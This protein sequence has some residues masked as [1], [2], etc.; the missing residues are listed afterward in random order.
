MLGL[1]IFI[2]TACALYPYREELN[3]TPLPENHLLTS[4]EFHSESQ[5]FQ[6][7]ETTRHYTVFPRSIGSLLDSTNTKEVHLRFANGWWDPEVYGRLPDNG[8]HSGGTGIE[9][10]AGIDADTQEMAFKEWKKLANGLSGIF[11]ASL[12]FID[13]DST[14]IP[15]HL[16][17]SG[18]YTFRS[19]LARE[20]VC[21]ENLTPFVKMLP[22]S[23]KTGI[24]SLL[25]GHT[26]F[27]AQWTGMAIDAVKECSDGHCQYKL[28]QYVDTV[29]KVP[30]ALARVK[31]Q[32][33]RPIAGD[34]L[35]C[36]PSKRHD[37]FH[38]FPLEDPK[39]SRF[40]LKQV[41]GRVVEGKNMVSSS[42]KVCVGSQDSVWEAFAKLNHHEEP[43]SQVLLN[44]DND[45]CFELENHHRVNLELVSN[46]SSQTVHSKAP[47][48]VSRSATGRS[49]DFGK[50]QSRLHN[51]SPEPVSVVYV[52]SLPWFL[53]L[54]VNTMHIT[55]RDSRTKKV[56]QTI[57]IS[58]NKALEKL[59][60]KLYYQTAI[61]RKRP[62]HIELELEIPAYTIV[63]IGYEFEKSLLLY[64]EY[65]PD[66]N[67]GFDIEPAAVYVYENGAVKYQARTTS[68]VVSLPTPDFS[69]P[70]N[71]III[72]CTLMSLVFGAIFNMLAKRT[73]T[74]EE[75]DK[76]VG[77][78]GLQAKLKMFWRGEKQK[79]E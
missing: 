64:A 8:E 29:V 52:E 4:F 7:N 17:S 59:K 12:N 38:C 67:H 42:T 15:H 70:Y 61:D 63:T 19:A 69:M 37:A 48:L 31:N 49:Q 43:H 20:P 75:A 50:M 78:Y 60:G 1:P 3:V 76:L 74:E 13:S 23:G 21:T 66:A 30:K 28:D 71:V 39:E 36:D 24:A 35:R 44:G 45:Y 5:S 32:I 9:L 10:L 47:I 53:R 6:P 16:S 22:S 25:D 33:P 65:P 72:T 41:F 46:D 62:T 77:E 54:F 11:C 2:A 27:D 34:Q 57:S 56:H 55:L 68:L 73:V 40:D 18:R 58:D 79:K 26:V 14:T 51:Y